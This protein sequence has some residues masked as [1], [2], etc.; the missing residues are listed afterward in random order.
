MPW[1]KLTLHVEPQHAE[2]LSEWLAEAGAIAVTL[3]DAGDRP[4]FETHWEEPPRWERVRVSALFPE[5]VDAE[6]LAAEAASRFG[7]EAPG[8]A[9]LSLLDDAD[10]AESWKAHYKPFAVGRGL[11]VV[12]S[13]CEPLQPGAVNL[14][15][16]PGLAFGTGEHPTTALCLEWMAEQ[17]LAGASVLDYGCGSGILAIAALKLGAAEAW[18]VDIDPQALEVARLN[19]E[20]NGVAARL[21][22]LDPS[23]LPAGLQTDIVVANI[24]AGA[25]IELAPQLSARTRPGGSLALS[26]ILAEQAA[27]VRAHYAATFAFE[28]RHRSGWVLLAGRKAV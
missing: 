14:I 25:L 26:G 21:H 12:P 20:R 11:W 22:V 4:F 9:A 17:P 23:A 13:W 5:Q 18:A 19:A 28:E 10:W 6:A 15:I 2:S 24:L 1:L 3:E 7:L 8:A 16:D 27:D